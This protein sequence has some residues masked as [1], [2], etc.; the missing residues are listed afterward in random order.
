LLKQKGVKMTDKELDAEMR[1]YRETC[2]IVDEAQNTSIDNPYEKLDW[3]VEA[4]EAD[5]WVLANGGW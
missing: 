4:E 5:E 3:W 2:P 1:L